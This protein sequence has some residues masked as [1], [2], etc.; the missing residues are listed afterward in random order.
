[1]AGDVRERPAGKDER[2]T[3]G[4][5]GT[6]RA[7][8]E[9]LQKRGSNPKGELGSPD[10]NSMTECADRTGTQRHLPCRYT[11]FICH[12]LRHCCIA[13]K[14]HNNKAAPRKEGTSLGACL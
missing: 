6:V 4:E 2:K 8:Q 5:A 9:C 3:Q 12:C 14:R 7:A 1:M 11:E 10:S 13:V